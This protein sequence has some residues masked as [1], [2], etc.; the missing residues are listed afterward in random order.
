MKRV[1]TGALALALFAFQAAPVVPGSGAEAQKR[2]SLG[3]VYSGG[4]A[5]RRGRGRGPQ[6]RSFNRSVGGYSYRAPDT[7]NTYGDNRSR[8][9]GTSSY[10]D[11][12]LDTQTR[13]G[14]FDHGWFFDSGIN[15]NGGNSPYF[16]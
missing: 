9:G 16:Q 8:F 15:P 7:I 6:V 14:P 13:A 12:S 1:L 2:Q 11:P 4:G 3:K 5:R 10:R